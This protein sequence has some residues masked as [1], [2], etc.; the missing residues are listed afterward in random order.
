MLGNKAEI[1]ATRETQEWIVRKQAVKVGYL[2]EW[3]MEK[4]PTQQTNFEHLLC[5]MSSVKPFHVW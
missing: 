1:Q 2:T 5:A 4:I 3:I